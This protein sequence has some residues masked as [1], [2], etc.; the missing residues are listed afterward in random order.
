MKKLLLTTVLLLSSVILF[1]QENLYV[2]VDNG[3]QV[4]YINKAGQVVFK[5]DTTGAEIRDFHNYRNGYLIVE[6]SK[7]RK[8][9]I[10]D[11]K[12]NKIFESTK[13]AFVNNYR[14]VP[15]DNHYA[16]VALRNTYGVAN[17]ESI[18]GVV[19]I[20]GNFTIPGS[21]ENKSLNYAGGNMFVRIK[22]N[23]RTAEFE[24]ID[25]QGKLIQQFRHRNFE[26]SV[27]NFSISEN[28]IPFKFVTNEFKSI[29]VPPNKVVSDKWGYMD[30]EKNLVIA[31]QYEKAYPFSEGFATVLTSK[32][33][34]DI[35]NKKGVS[36][37]SPKFDNYEISTSGPA[38]PKFVNGLANVC[39]ID[40]KDAN[41]TQK[42]GYIDTLAN[43]VI[44]PRYVYAS[45][46]YEGMAEVTDAD[47]KSRLIDRNGKTIVEGNWGSSEHKACIWDKD[48][49]Y[50]WHLNTY[51]DHKGNVI[52]RPKT[53]H[54]TI[55]I[56]AQL[57][58]IKESDLKYVDEIAFW[59]YKPGKEDYLQ[60]PEFLKKILKCVNLKRLHISGM[61]T[62]PGLP[63]FKE[64]YKLSKLEKITLESSEI[65]V[66]PDGISKLQKL[67]FLNLRGAKISS[68]PAD[69]HL[70]KLDYLNIDGTPVD[71]K[72]EIVN[73]IKR[74]VKQLE[75][76][77]RAQISSPD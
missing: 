23:G 6:Y 7:A 33:A 31:P 15:F 38:Q 25:G 22:T 45:Y 28:R 60:K 9:A 63:F 35:I 58:N 14:F 62:D 34:Y 16:I 29:L 57:N 53:P 72:E 70:L 77:F 55:N 40:K 64:I 11:S 2:A 3:N 43:W 54:Y 68:F 10:F 73:K 36:I 1:A 52:W 18:C 59:N 12:G 13:I 8:S 44:E 51:F 66:L 32:G 27:A 46:F 67:K 42:C 69:F 75:R 56:P 24:L 50:V 76:G 71:G 41:T 48:I 19:D 37:L 20:N 61:K 47:L 26:S 4:Y 21:N 5:M 30:I 74:N 17:A 39:I 65:K 49:I